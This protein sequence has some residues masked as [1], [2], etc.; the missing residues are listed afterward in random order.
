MVDFLFLASGL[1]M[2][3]F[4]RPLAKLFAEHQKFF[5]WKDGADKF[6]RAMYVVM[7]I[8]FTL[9]GLLFLL[10]RRS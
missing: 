2:L 7:G 3:V 9:V 5:G 4:N 10:R 8:I 1:M 6:G